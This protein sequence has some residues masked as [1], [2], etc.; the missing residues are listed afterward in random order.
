VKRSALASSI[1]AVLLLAACSRHLSPSPGGDDGQ[2]LY[3]ICSAG[4]VAPEAAL[5]IFVR[6]TFGYTLPLPAGQKQQV[7]LTVLNSGSLG[8]T[9]MA[10]LTSQSSVLSYEGGTYPGTGGD[11]GTELAAGATCT[12]VVDVVAPATGRRPP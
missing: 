4:P 1:G 2:T 6:G 8:A 11:C 5:G 3:G 12:L 10:D 9:Q 7:T